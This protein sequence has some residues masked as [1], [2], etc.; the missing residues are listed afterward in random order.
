MKKSINFALSL[1]ILSCLIVIYRIIFLKRGWTVLSLPFNI[2]QTVSLLLVVPLGLL[3]VAIF[4]NV[5]GVNTFGTFIPVLL[6]IVLMETRLIWGLV[7]FFF[8]III[9]IFAK[10]ILDKFKLLFISRLSFTITFVIVVL[11][12]L[13][14]VSYQAGV[15]TISCF[16]LLPLIIMIMVVERFSITQLESGTQY[17]LIVSLG[18]IM[19]A[20]LVYWIISFEVIQLFMSLFPELLL[21][22][23]GLLI[24]IGCYTG[25]RWTEL[26]RFRH[27]NRL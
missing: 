19:V 7:L 4:R 17:S 5:I 11:V 2:Q 22:V 23:L 8:V 18:T 24:V 9:S 25:L 14:I 13:I 16:N 20:C 27:I 10:L 12:A 26:L 15:R 1:I 3:I 21:A 6:A